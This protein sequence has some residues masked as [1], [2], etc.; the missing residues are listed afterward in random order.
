[1]N[2][3]KS[4]S[5]SAQVANTKWSGFSKKYATFAEQQKTHEESARLEE[6]L[7]L[8]FGFCQ[9]QDRRLTQVASL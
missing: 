6:A 2:T 9:R 7:V 1:M 3:S 8:L 4:Q 5:A